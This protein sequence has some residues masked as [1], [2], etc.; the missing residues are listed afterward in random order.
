MCP[1]IRSIPGSILKFRFDF[2]SAESQLITEQTARLKAQND[3]AVAI[4][5]MHIALET[6]RASLANAPLADATTRVNAIKALREAQKA[7]EELKSST[8]S[9]AP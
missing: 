7:L 1:G 4:I 9:T 5:N 8:K 2:T 6:A 3:Q